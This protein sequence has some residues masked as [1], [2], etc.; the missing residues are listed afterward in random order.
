MTPGD[1][2]EEHVLMVIVAGTAP[3]TEISL[4]AQQTIEKYEAKGAR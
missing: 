4:K 2:N 1:M 3:G